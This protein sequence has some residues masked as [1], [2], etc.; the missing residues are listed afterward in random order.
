[1]T[2]A[3]GWYPDPLGRQRWRWFDGVV[4]TSETSAT[5]PIGAADLPSE[6]DPWDDED[7]L[8]EAELLARSTAGD[9]EDLDHEVDDA[10][11]DTDAWPDDDHDDEDELDF[12]DEG[13]E[14][15]LHDEAD[16]WPDDEDEEELELDEPAT[17]EVA[18]VDAP[19]AELWVSEDRGWDD[20][21]A[22]WLAS[23]G[24]D[25]TSTLEAER[26]PPPPTPDL[27]LEPTEPAHL[28]TAAR[29]PRSPYRR[30]RLA[31]LALV[32]GAVVVVVALV[33]RGSG[34]SGGGSLAADHLALTYHGDLL[35][36]SDTT[37]DVVVDGDDLL[38]DRR[39]GDARR[40]TVI[41]DG[42]TYDCPLDAGAGVCVRSDAAD[43]AAAARASAL[44]FLDPLSTD[45][46][47]GRAA[48]TAAKSA[49]RTVAGRRSECSTL[50]VPGQAGPYEVC[51]DAKLKFLTSAKGRDVDLALQ[52]VRVPRSGEVQVPEGV[53]VE[54]EPDPES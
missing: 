36:V 32:A 25:A 19:F 16:A 27:A 28:A 53:E 26:E 54:G 45:G 7:D 43:A 11:W 9:H 42:A 2:D 12:D 34:G 17:P 47:F 22:Q 3:P 41:R 1:M 29:R 24:P 38:Q 46:T 8:T 44:L 18:S 20:A 40:V 5:R 50:T 13:E 35:G 23:T 37:I 48:E 14:L 6:P 15:D 39:A 33:Q 51:R 10:A 31:A 21:E 30:R 4:W 52:Q 49:D